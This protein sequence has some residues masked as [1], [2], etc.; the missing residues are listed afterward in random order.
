MSSPVP[1]PPAPLRAAALVLGALL[2]TASCSAPADREAPPPGVEGAERELTFPAGPH[3][4]H[5]TFTAPEA[6][7]A[8]ARKVP[9]ALIVSGSGPTDRDGNS[10]LR[11]EADTNLNFARV[12]ADAGVASLRYDKLGSGQTGPGSAEEDPDGAPGADYAAFEEQMA[13]AYRTL[14]DQPEVDPERV[15][16]LG[17]S[18]GGLFALRAHEALGGEEHLPSALVLAAPVGERYLDVIDRQL[19]ESVRSAESRGWLSAQDAVR[20]LSDARQGRA[21]VRSGEEIPPGF[22]PG[23]EGLYDS[24]TGPF[25]AQIDA[26]DPLELAEGLPADTSTL[27]LW[28]EADAQITEEEVDRL[29]TGL[30]QATR[31]DVPDADHIFR[32]YDDSPG[33]V[34]LDAHREFAPQVAPA[35]RAF[36][37]E[38]L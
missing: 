23:L 31:V 6:D 29:M 10:P 12:L 16:V 28:G 34:A 27:V 4:L 5:A 11:P 36:L 38:A 37:R 8:S 26:M 1:N 20:L 3:T 15:L 7:A 13:A 22:S 19:T 35:L 25:L 24:A 32:V 33:A 18:E 17:H 30:P 21:L 2:L 9:G 14:L